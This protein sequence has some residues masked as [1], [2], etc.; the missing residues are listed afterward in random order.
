MIPQYRGREFQA[1]NQFTFSNPIHRAGNDRNASDGIEY[2]TWA[3]RIKGKYGY[4]GKSDDR[5]FGAWQRRAP[6]NHH[7]DQ[8]G[9]DE[10]GRQAK[11]EGYDSDVPSPPLWKK[12]GSP[13]AEQ[14]A[15]AIAGYRQ[16]MLEIVRDMPETAYELSLR[17]L[18]ESPR[19]AKPPV[20]QT[21]G[22]GGEFSKDKTEKE[23]RKKG[24]RRMSRSESMDPGG[25]L[26]KMFLPNPL[27]GRRKKSFGGSSACAKV[28]PQDCWKKNTSDEKGSSS[29]SSSS[30]RS[31]TRK[32]IGCYSFFRTN[33]HK[34]GEN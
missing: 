19:I 13:M 30:S 14:L 25:F 11:Q 12:P 10:F 18:V 1:R 29:S 8:V 15:Q 6:L 33:K 2:G 21:L 26:L 20:Q 7:G 34:D 32:V 24:I 23:K 27:T 28:S 31:R 5:N 22:K 3:E 16:E 17:D 4:F 9:E